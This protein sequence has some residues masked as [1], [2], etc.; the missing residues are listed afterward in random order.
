[1]DALGAA[2]EG[3]V[4]ARLL[5]HVAVHLGAARNENHLVADALLLAEFGQLL[6]LGAVHI[7]VADDRGDQDRLGAGLD[8]GVH[9]LAHGHGGAEVVVL[10]A[11]FLDAAVLDVQDL[12]QAHRMLIL[13]YRA[14]HDAQSD[15]LDRIPQ[16]LLGQDDLLLGDLQRGL[17]DIEGHL[18]LHLHEA[19]FGGV[20]DHGVD[21]LGIEETHLLGHLLGVDRG[22][23][24]VLG[25]EELDEH[26]AIPGPFGLG[27]D[28]VALPVRQGLLQ[29]LVAVVLGVQLVDEDDL[30]GLAEGAS[31]DGV[32]GLL[33]SCGQM[34]VP[35]VI[36]DGGEVVRIPQ[37][38]GTRAHAAL[39]V[40]R[41]AVAVAFGILGAV[42]EETLFD[43]GEVAAVLDDLLQEG[44]GPLLEVAHHLAQGPF[45]IEGHEL[46]DAIQGGPGLLDGL[47]A[48]DVV[49]V[50]GHVAPLVRRDGGLDIGPRQHGDQRVHRMGADGLLDIGLDVARV[51]LGAHLEF[52]EEVAQGHGVGEVVPELGR[53]RRIGGD[54]GEADE[55][56]VHAHGYREGAVD[57]VLHHELGHHQPAGL[58]RGVGVVGAIDLEDAG[59]G[60][61]ALGLGGVHEGTV[62]VHV[63]VEDVVLGILVGAIDALFR[64]EH[65]DL[66]TGHA[67]DV[68][69]EVDGTAHLL[70]DLV[71][72][73]SRGA[74]LLAGDGHAAD[75]F[76]RSFQQ[77]V[78]VALARG[79]DHH[80]VVRAVPGGHAHAADI[81]L[82]APGGDLGGHDALGLGIDVVEVLGGGKADGVLQGHGHVPVVEGAHV[83]AFRGH[84]APGP[85]LAGRMVVLQVL[86]DVLDVELL[87]GIQ[88][89]LGHVSILPRRGRS[90]RSCRRGW[91]GLRPGYPCRSSG[92]A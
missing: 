43:S 59:A 91:P 6:H 73:L 8:G 71:A 12:A 16:F 44:H 13:A 17:V 22:D 32:A 67:G 87:G 3:G 9:Q 53:G 1:M 86:E 5:G 28:H 50:P 57:A 56:F 72:G 54:G 61:D 90:A 68:A 49:V 42:H 29:A 46:L 25:H 89:L 27:L 39:A 15:L 63:A 81:V 48:A 4:Q 19:A 40:A 34:V 33:D 51:L 82:E 78:D 66:G 52:A 79:A 55:V 88:R 11:V 60:H 58:G 75:A 35:E 24:L 84:V 69:M 80:E 76:G 14:S 45:V 92:R 85:A 7:V 41:D 21:D 10:D 23:V 65:G 2:A 38:E 30:F 20:H 74:D 26:R 31:A 18:A 47:D 37:H 62:H 83:D 36:T 70:L 64:E 77:T